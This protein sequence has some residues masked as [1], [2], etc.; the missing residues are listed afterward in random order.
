[1]IAQCDRRHQIKSEDFELIAKGYENI[2]KWTKA[3][4]RC[5]NY[6]GTPSNG[7][8]MTLL[9]ELDELENCCEALT[10]ENCVIFVLVTKMREQHEKMGEQEKVVAV[11]KGESAKGH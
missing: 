5:E 1:M 6:S 2:V 10:F 9:A 4:R 11:T 3:V 8:Y 7:S